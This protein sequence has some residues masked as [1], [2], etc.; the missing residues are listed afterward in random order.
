MHCSADVKVLYLAWTLYCWPSCLYQ[1]YQYWSSRLGA[2][3]S[4]VTMRAA[5]SASS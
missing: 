3:W 5:I 1:K 4:T 2:P